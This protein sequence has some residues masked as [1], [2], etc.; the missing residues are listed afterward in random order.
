[1][2]EVYFFIEV[3]IFLRRAFFVV[4]FIFGFIIENLICI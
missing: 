1:M 2:I 3:E 4:K